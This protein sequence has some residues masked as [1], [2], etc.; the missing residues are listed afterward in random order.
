MRNV[1]S[2]GNILQMRLMNL[3][4]KKN[5]QIFRLMMKVIIIYPLQIMI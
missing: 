5:Y 1:M 4:V 2:F 3:K